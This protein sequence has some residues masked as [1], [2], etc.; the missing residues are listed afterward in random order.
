MSDDPRKMV[1]GVSHEGQ[2]DGVPVVLIGIPESAW[3]YIKTGKTSHF[4]FTNIGV[5]VKLIIFGAPTRAE[6]LSVL[7]RVSAP[8]CKD[9]RSID[10]GMSN[11]KASQ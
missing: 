4:D 6:A 10:I 11:R 2:G 5:P 3:D 9:L 1:F 7:E 8:D